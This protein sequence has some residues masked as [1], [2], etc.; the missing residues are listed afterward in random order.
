MRVPV[1]FTW[2]G[3]EDGPCRG[4]GITRDI[5]MDGAYIYSR[6]CP[7]INAIV[8]MEILL[9]QDDGAASTLITGKM[10]TER[11][12]E[13]G[14]EDGHGRQRGG[15]SVHG[16]ELRLERRLVSSARNP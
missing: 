9:P 13:D 10:R 1:T 14:R 4:E 8:R 16:Q 12:E 6:T 2:E 11:V 15:F 7:P 3:S 5:S